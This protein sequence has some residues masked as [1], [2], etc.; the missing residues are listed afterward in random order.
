MSKN[1]NKGY[2]KRKCLD[3]ANRE[4]VST[5]AHSH[6]VKPFRTNSQEGRLYR[7]YPERRGRPTITFYTD[8]PQLTYRTNTIP[9]GGEI[10][11]HKRKAI[12]QK[13]IATERK[14]FMKL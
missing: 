4:A 1:K 2:V 3:A 10:T 11:L 7:S 14:N 5:V 12:I 8:A 9:R 6:R 13:Q